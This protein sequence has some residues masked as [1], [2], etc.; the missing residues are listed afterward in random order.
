MKY[1]EMNDDQKK[2]ILYQLYETD[3]KSFGDIAKQLATYSNKIR[4]DAIKFKLK[5]RNKSD[6]QKNALFT[7][8]HKHPTKGTERDDQTKQKIGGAVMKSWSNISEEE[9]YNR[10]QMAK[11]QWNKKSEDDKKYMQQK[12]NAAVRVSSKEGSKLEK[13]LLNRLVKDGFKVKF[14]EE[15]IL[16][17]TKLQIDILIPSMN[18]A[19]EIDGPSHFLPVWGDD[20]LNRNQKYDNKKE[21]L[22][23][24][25]GLYLIRIKQLKDF[26][27]SRAE[28]IYLNLK[29]I[30]NNLDSNTKQY[31]IEDK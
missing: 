15:Q 25:R 11:E 22:I 13:Y 31:F 28:L 27:K 21:G 10:K 16:S 3:K 30:I 6:A 17:N 29:N 20:A 23:I 26:S 19:I 24:G 14:H 4:R 2:Q 8:K 7:G 18:V 5:I 12:A 9:L 1:D